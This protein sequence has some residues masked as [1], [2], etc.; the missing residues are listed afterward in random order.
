MAKLTTK[1]VQNLTDPGTYEDGNG[2]RL[3]VK[4]GGRKSWI[5]RYQ[6]NGRRREMGLGPFESVSLKAARIKAAAQRCL[7]LEGRDPIDERRA[8]QETQNRESGRKVTFEAVALAYIEA[9]RPG[10]KS[11]KHGKQW[12][13]TLRTYAFP[14][15]GR[16]APTE[17]TTEDVLAILQPI[18]ESRPETARR[19]RNRIE[20]ILNSAKAQNLREGENVAA[21]RGHL[22]LLLAK[23]KSKA[24]GHHTALPWQQV[25]AF[26]Q[27]IKD[28]SDLSAYAVRLTLLTAL[29]T[30]EVIGARWGEIDLEAKEWLVPA[31]RMKAKK[32]H[33]VPL[34][35]AAV[36]ELEAMPHIAGSD[37]LFPGQRGAHH[38]SNMAMLQKV[39]G[40]DEIKF[41][42]DSQGWRDADGSVI[43]I[44]GLRSSFRDW[45]AECSHSPNYVAEMAL[46]HTIGNDVEKAYRR[47]DLLAKRAE[48]MEQ[49]ATHVT[50][51]P[52]N[53]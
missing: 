44:H 30:S 26:W 13:A 20:I 51:V 47:G 38:M 5:F 8:Q 46:A 17:I 43:T 22:E 31:S 35:A 29:R 36:A 42:K 19:V 40:M 25:P 14:H 28:H 11:R 32:A 4:R 33:R 3:V 49:W 6:V 15:I 48:L 7:I 24:R 18:W 10:W 34:S 9:Q 21:W 45:A 1:K 16:K 12:E 39:R 53:M 50:T 23:Q 27:A 41:E 37:Y 2:L 52:V